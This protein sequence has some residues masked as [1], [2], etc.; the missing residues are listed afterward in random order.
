MKS[1]IRVERYLVA[2]LL[3]ATTIAPS[4]WAGRQDN[5]LRFAYEQVVE[6]LDPYFNSVRGGFIIS[7]QVWD[8]LIYRDPKTHEYKGQLATAWRWID[9]RTLELALRRGVKFHNGDDFD[10]DDVVYTLNFVHDPA[11]G[12]VVQQNVNWIEK[13]EKL[14]NYTVRIIARTPF[15]AAIEY[16]AG[17][18]VIHPHAYYARVGP[19]GM[20]EHPIGSGP[21]R[22][23]E[24][25]LGKSVRLERNPAYFKE[26]PKSRP[27]IERVDIRFIPDRQTQIAEVLSGGVDFVMNIGADQAVPLRARSDLQ[28][29]FGETMRIA[30]L[31]FDTTE[32]SVAPALRDIRV[33]Q[34]IMHA[35]DRDS[36]VKSLVGEGSRVLHV[37]CFPSQLG[38]ADDSAPRYGYDPVTSKRL[39]AEA[40]FANGFEVDVFA[41]RDRPHTEAIVGNLRAIGI[42]AN[43]RFQPYATVRDAL[44]AGKAPIVNQSWGSFSINDVS[45][46]TSVFFKFTPD[47]VTRDP[48][49][50]A[51]LERGDS[52]LDERV[53]RQ[54]YAAALALIQERA[55]ALPLYSLPIYYLAAKDLEFSAYADEIPRFWEMNWK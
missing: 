28:V 11:N 44:R 51:L 47:D 12:V 49:V 5:S 42:R 43:L 38:C 30:F 45:A 36:M 14:D 25:V 50:R 22:V 48:E 17:P 2:A 46:S 18:I 34:A 3:A 24:H 33:R 52:A 31:Q 15:P 53:R 27:R 35:I 32:R 26:S 41:T 6:H 54:S 10:A 55:Y 29:V 8:T 9:D 16:L 1:A 7:Q 4:A 19:Q 39:L 37:V 20:S 40:G 13:V 21:Y 23:T